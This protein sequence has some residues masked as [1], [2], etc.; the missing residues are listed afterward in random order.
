MALS[1][2]W[3]TKVITIPQADLIALGGS[4][5]QL[6]TDQFHWDLRDYMDSEDGIVHLP[7]HTYV[8][9]TTLAGFTYAPLLEI[10][11]GYTV[12]FEDGS[13][14]VYLN[15]TNNNIL[16]VLNFNS[17]QVAAQNSAGLVVNESI[18]DVLEGSITTADAL[19]IILAAVAGTTSGVGS[20]NELYKSIDGLKN[21]I[22]VDF[23]VDSNRTSVNLDGSV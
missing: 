7:T 9:A 1:I 13:Y 18:N 2:D 14:R 10:I 19:R 23:D 4:N 15:G 17:V 21:R 16:D 5:Y 3:A 20:T 11:N 12:T 22:D 6:D 8:A